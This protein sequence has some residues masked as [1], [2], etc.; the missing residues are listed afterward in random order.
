MHG[1]SSR[2]R[3]SISHL[4]AVSSKCSSLLL[5]MSFNSPPLLG[6]KLLCALRSQSSN[7]SSHGILAAGQ[8][9]FQYKG[10]LSRT[11]E[12]KLSAALKPTAPLG[13]DLP[14]SARTN[15]SCETMPWSTGSAGP[16][17]LTDACVHL[18][19]KRCSRQHTL[20]LMVA[21]IPKH[22]MDIEQ[23]VGSCRAKRRSLSQSCCTAPS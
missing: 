8:P 3:Q 15:A 16:F 17:S 22:K 6:T 4:K 2:T 21:D 5:T 18:L 19:A 23:S 14:D 9:S 12:R 7:Y 11:Y 1:R 13:Q 10:S 20:R